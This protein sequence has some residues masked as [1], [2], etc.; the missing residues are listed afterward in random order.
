MKTKGLAKAK[1]MRL[2]QV[3]DLLAEGYA[4]IIGKGVP[5]WAFPASM[6]WGAPGIGKSKGI[7]QFASLL[8]E[9]TGKRVAVTDVRLI[10]FNPIDL[11]GIPIASADKEFA[12]WLRPKVFDMDAGEDAIN[13]LFLDEL[14]SALPS[15]Q[16]AAYQITLDR[17]IGEHRLPDN[18][19]VVAAGNRMTDRSVAYKMPKALA[20]RL[21]HFDIEADFRTWKDWAI[22]HG[23]DSKVTG[24]L[25]F[26]PDLLMRFDPGSDELA[27]PS[28]RSW[29]MVS[30]ILLHAV[31]DTE[32][33][34]PVIAG[35]IGEGAAI[36]FLAW[37]S[38]FG[39]LPSIEG[40][41]AGKEREIPQ[42]TDAL[43]ALISSMT[44]YASEHA[45][46][47]DAIERSIEYASRM[48]VDFATV[49]FKDYMQISEEMKMALMR[50]QAFLTWAGRERRFFDQ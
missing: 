15:V 43:Y 44:L 41:F 42:T 25:S 11:R 46:D 8:G 34:F 20:N 2:Q 18:C 1:G 37:V 48:P 36:E 29:E 45:V 21:C 28:P 23:L 47:E 6:L 3:I 40:I 14:S 31:S 30:N 12:I 32:R 19:I 4:N 35:C 16:A 38:V 22:K 17:K 9:M 5:V 39:I 26:K 24:F 7:L 13:I 49:L 10:L 33:A 50:S 27:F